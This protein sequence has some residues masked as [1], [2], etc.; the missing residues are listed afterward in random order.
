MEMWQNMQVML[1]NSPIFLFAFLPTVLIIY[2][3][4]PEK[5][6]NLF[7]LFA[8]AFFYWWGEPIFIK[9]LLLV[10]LANYLVA[11]L[12]SYYNNIVKISR[13]FLLIGITIN[14]SFLFYFKYSNFFLENISWMLPK[15]HPSLTQV[16][17]PLAISFFTFHALSYLIDVYKKKISVQ[18]NPVKLG[19]YFLLFP[20]LLAGPIVRLSDIENQLDKRVVTLDTISYGVVRF[21]TG[22]AKK[23][24]IADTLAPFIDEIFATPTIHLMPTSALLGMVGYTLQIYFDFSGYSDMAIGLAS[25]F[26]FRFPENFNYPYFATSVT[27]FWRRWHMTLSNWFRDYLYI[28][29]GGNRVSPI[30]NYFNLL[31]VFILVGLWHGAGRSFIFWG[32]YQG[33]FLMFERLTFLKKLSG[34]LSLPNLYNHIYLLIIVMIGWVFF[35]S[36]SLNYAVSYINQLIHLF[37]HQAYINSYHSTDYFIRSDVLL[38]LIVGSLLSF[39]VVKLLPKQLS[40][41]PLARVISLLLLTGLFLLSLTATAVQTYNPFIYFRF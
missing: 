5:I 4:L 23:V 8:S 2:F 10:V 15:I 39:P 7:L 35:R 31:I 22:L 20:H 37:D 28:P 18:T 9:N 17:L 41:T 25:M 40:S 16:V 32:L 13:T 11:Y 36:S 27:E 6:K 33:I 38:A 3:I 34:K 1:F 26:G 12:I 14:L 21:I 19:L 29:L 30:R 24:L